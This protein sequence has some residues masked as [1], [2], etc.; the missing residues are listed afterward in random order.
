MSSRWSSGTSEARRRRRPGRALVAGAAGA[1][2]LVL[3][4]VIALATRSSPSGSPTTRRATSESTTTG[5]VSLASGDDAVRGLPPPRAVGRLLVATSDCRLELVTVAT[6]GITRPRP[7]VASCMASLLP[8][9][10]FAV[11][12]VGGSNSQPAW[13]RLGRRPAEDRELLPSVPAAWAT[14]P[15]GQVA[16]CD[17]RTATPRVSLFAVSGTA[18]S[19]PGCSPAWW[20]GRLVRIAPDGA[21]VDAS[22]RLLESPMRGT[23]VGA[24]SLGASPDGSHLALVQGRAPNLQALIYDRSGRL[25][26]TLPLPYIGGRL[27]GVRLSNDG[28]LVAVLTN[29]RWTVARTDGSVTPIDDV[30][31]SIIIDVAMAP[32]SGAVAIALA[33]R[34]VFLD[35]A[36]LGP[37]AQLPVEAESLDWAP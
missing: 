2:L 35:P 19:L 8:P 25:V 37:V 32:D 4:L 27:V 9:P 17:G 1:V 14:G 12:A 21:I 16:T 18:R 6:R 23:V 5:A 29:A 3:G 28:N 22:G 13:R 10:G 33:H 34:I 7:D 31:Q 24:S 15:A 36:T 26:S 20:R 30:A 11:A